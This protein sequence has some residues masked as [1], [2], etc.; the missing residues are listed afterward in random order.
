MLVKLISAVF[1]YNLIGTLWYS[2][3]LFARTFLRTTHWPKGKKREMT[4]GMLLGSM[5]MGLLEVLGLLYLL[6]Q[7]NIDTTWGGLK[8]GY[9]IWQ[10]F[11]FPSMA[12]HYFFDRRPLEHLA[13]VTSHHLVS[14]TLEGALLGFLSARRL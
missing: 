7:S 12:V 13:M 4:L 14:L 2:P 9:L 5:A 8:V 10:F 6:H 11:V 3:L 1:L